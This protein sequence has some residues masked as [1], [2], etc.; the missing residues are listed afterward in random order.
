MKTF[1]V[2]V[3]V[4]F[5]FL[6]LIGLVFGSW[7]WGSYNTLVVSSTQVDTA[8]ASVQTQYQRRFDL[9][10]NLVEAAK[11]TMEQEQAVFGAIAQARTQYAGART[12]TDQAGAATQYESAIGR[13]L[14]VMENY[15]VLQ[16][17][18]TVQGLMAELSGTENRVQ[19]GRD[20]YNQSVQ[21]YN[22][23]IKQFPK[24]LIAGVFGYEPRLMFSSEAAAAIAP[25]VNLDLK[26]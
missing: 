5:A 15:P 8:W 2:V 18:S 21:S 26:K 19:V 22:I 6:L 17:N 23:T 20:R 7:L 11:G 25:S 16:S 14:V 12:P 13:L 10:P 4:I 1:G 9:I 3:G 24:N